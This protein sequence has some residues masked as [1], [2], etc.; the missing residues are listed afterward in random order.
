ML[1]ATELGSMAADM[2]GMLCDVY[3][4]LEGMGAYVLRGASTGL[5]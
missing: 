4:M 2:L 5:E 1:S 3:S